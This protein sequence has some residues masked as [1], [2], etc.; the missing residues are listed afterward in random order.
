M[1]YDDLFTLLIVVNSILGSEFVDRSI[2]LG[3]NS[4]L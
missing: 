3:V 1:A 2:D 4:S